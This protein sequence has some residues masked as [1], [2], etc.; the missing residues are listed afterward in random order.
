[1]IDTMGQ[2]MDEAVTG[3]VEDHNGV[4]FFIGWHVRQDELGRNIPGTGAWRAHVRIVA[5]GHSRNQENVYVVKDEHK[6]KHAT[7][8]RTFEAQLPARLEGIQTTL[9]EQMAA[10][11]SLTGNVSKPA[12]QKRRGRPPKQPQESPG[13]AANPG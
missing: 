7:K 6:V 5:P 13:V 1:V 3:R 12:P 8:W 9:E 2:A 10:L 11:R 4:L